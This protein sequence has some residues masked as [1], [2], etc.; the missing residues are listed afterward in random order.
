MDRLGL[1]VGAVYLKAVLLD[2]DG[3]LFANWYRPHRGEPAEAL[4]GLLGELESSGRL[5]AVEY[6]GLTGAAAAV[7]EP[8]GLSPLD[9]ARC[10]VA[11]VTRQPGR[12]A[13]VMD[14]GGASATLIQLDE[15][16]RIR[17]FTTNSM[18]AAGTGAFLDEQAARLG[19]S[20]DQLGDF[21]YVEE[22][23]TIAT[24]CA[25]FAK[26]DLIHRQQEGCSKA[27][28]WSGLC[29]GM[30]RTLLGTLLS[31][32]PLDG[33]TMVIG[34]VAQNREFI[35]WL[36]EA[37]PKYI[38]VP[39][40][41][42]LQAAIGAALLAPHLARPLSAS[43]VQRAATASPIERYA[44]PLSMERSTYP[45]FEVAE[46]YTDDA[47]NEVRVTA[48]TPGEDV[49][50]Y[51]GID[52]GSTS[53]KLALVDDEERVLVDIYR[54]TAGDPIGASGKLFRALAT[55]VDRTGARLHILGAA[56]TGSGRKIVGAIAGA[57]AVINEISA[58]V[59]GAMKTDPGIDTIFEIGGQDAKY[60]YVVDGNMRHANMNYVCAA[61]T[62]SFVEE[63]ATKLGY[64]VGD[65]GRAVLGLHPPR[66]SDRCTVFM[67][68][69]VGRLV[70]A[71]AT[72]EDALAAVMVAVVKNYLNKVVGN[73]PRSRTRIFFQGATA[74]NPALVAAFERVLDV[75]VVV[76]PYCHVMGAYGVAL[77][78]RQQMIEHPAPSRFRGLDLDRRH[79]ELR[80]ERCDLCNNDCAITVASV[81]GTDDHPSW[82]YQC[83]R[84]PEDTKVKV[85]PNDRLVR[86]RQRL[87][88][89]G[90]RGVSVPADAP[91]I[92][93]PQALMTYSHLPLWQKFFNTLGFALKLS[94]PSDD[95][96]RESG[97]RL[98]GADF[99]FPA[100]VAIGHLAKL[101]AD[102][103]ID[104]V[105]VPQFLS[106]TV[107]SG[108]SGAFVCPYVQ[109]LAAYGK[110][111]LQL[112]G[113]PIDRLLSPVVDLRHEEAHVVR[114]LDDA[115]GVPLNRSR[116]RIRD[117][118]RAGRDAQAAFEERCRAE[119]R[120]ALAEAR[121]RGEKVTVLS[122]RP[123]NIY[124][125]GLN[126]DL[127]RKLADQGR[128]LLPLDMLDTDVAQR[129][130]QYTNIYWL[131]GKRILGA[132]AESAAS[133]DLDPVHLTNFNCGP[134]SFLLSFAEDVMGERPF[135]ALEL[136][137]HGSD[138]GYQTRIEA[139]SHVLSRAPARQPR[140][141]APRPEPDDF[142]ARTLW[143]PPMHPVGTSL[144]VAAFHRHGYKARE[145]PP[146]DQQ[147]YEI[148]RRVT[149]GS[150]C[151]PTSLTIGR[152]LQAMA[153]EDRPAEHALFM[154]TTQGPCRFGQYK[155][156]HRQILDREGY[157]DVAL[158]A[159]SSYNAYFGLDG[160]VRRTLWQAFVAGDIML[161]AVC[162][163][164]PYEVNPG[165]TD[166]VLAEL[167]PMVAD[168]VR[169]G[170]DLGAAV[171]QAV[172]RFAAVPTCRTTP[173]PLVGIVGEIYVRNNTFASEDVIRSIEQFGGEAWMSPM[174][175]WM[176]YVSSFDNQ[177]H[178]NGA[179]SLKTLRT[180][181]TFLWMK[182]QEDRLYAA[183]GP[184]LA[185]RHEPDGKKV[186]AAAR[187]WMP[188]NIG[189]EA[190]LTLGRAAA[191]KD[192]GAALVVN[193]S[194]FGCMP[195]ATTA[196]IFKQVS[197][198]IDL[199][200]VS[201]FY[202]G[203]GNQNRR[204]EAFLHSALDRRDGA[205]RSPQHETSRPTL[206]PGEFPLRLIRPG[207]RPGREGAGRPLP[208]P[209]PP[210]AGQSGWT[211]DAV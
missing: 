165:E 47:G 74:R 16:H 40:E 69:D 83:G 200:I 84:E 204:L 59:T 134:D 101:A 107:S 141:H 43:A 157:G 34:G 104:W 196:A 4:A 162:K 32:R 65:V 62:G 187:K 15:Q 17:N 94:G 117:A 85:S 161:K 159:P 109:G 13:V 72:R 131:S 64:K 142:K 57:D 184:Y 44:W 38:V 45:S 98:A 136:D 205:L 29:R 182:H 67:E 171:A 127:P 194:P 181:P 14:V 168:V 87:W 185:D 208:H 179:F 19:I 66:A 120:T 174:G 56:T 175:E 145:L 177:R 48:W 50:G 137:E 133:T 113:L 158:L 183:A 70:Q 191:F 41:P 195:G 163:T 125:K 71:G 140:I 12:T 36:T 75:P 154:P 193:C 148:G 152:F 54:K 21:S 39:P 190:L 189:G 192:D 147:T 10:Q 102:R 110:T 46:S 178:Q 143:L 5:A 108:T 53:T 78:V 95:E 170:G 25:V 150:E 206:R 7:G 1:D 172:E 76:S 209:A 93:L 31:G 35:R 61:G 9:L 139:F 49:R 3:R 130:P 80:S 198:E 68:S 37:A 128:L 26:S 82:G 203:T 30:T 123:Y 112:N 91:V 144:A 126:L 92:G 81:E 28:M 156:L 129:L 166:R 89:E 115:L 186:V 207:E 63:Q 149:R 211:S 103:A 18:C 79:V 96:V 99:C 121:R 86:L 210:P 197:V 58:H 6:A 146:E 176:L 106:E 20:Y 27:A 155:T 42:H 52:I 116:R 118:W 138:T 122:G 11:A 55:L 111:A 105:F 164:R 135:L 167:L 33:R 160:A 51:L 23:P 180:L 24:R 199:P 97:T 201:M 124:D 153:S 88:R 114:A 22:P 100:K 151:L 169:T 2:A 77:L 132:L 60:M 73:R 119:G 202:D 173:R 188:V 90:G 8:L